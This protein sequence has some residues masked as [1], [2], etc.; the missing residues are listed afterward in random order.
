MATKRIL[1]TI[2]LSNIGRGLLEALSREMGIDMSAVVELAIRAY[3]KSN[4][5]NAADLPAT[6]PTETR[7][8]TRTSTKN[9]TP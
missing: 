8:R 5:I 9:G 2:R 1:T 6:E 3:A 7:T 4:G